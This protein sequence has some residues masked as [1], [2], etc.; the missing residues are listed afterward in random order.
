MADDD[1][2]PVSHT[3][4][5]DRGAK[6]DRDKQLSGDAQL[7]SLLNAEINMQPVDYSLWSSD[8][9]PDPLSV[10]HRIEHTRVLKCESVVAC[11]ICMEVSGTHARGRHMLLHMADWGDDRRT[12]RSGRRSASSWRAATA[13]IEDALT[14][15]SRAI[16]G[17]PCAEWTC[18]RL[19]NKRFVFYS[20]II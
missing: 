17:A 9:E 15:G 6:R 16:G 1:C 12:S 11:V 18:R 2:V 13:F 4:A 3:R 14:S 19:R 10:D 7:A 20:S 5:A 8:V